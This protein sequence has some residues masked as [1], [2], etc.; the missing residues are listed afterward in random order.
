MKITKILGIIALIAISVSA[1]GESKSS[2][3]YVRNRSVKI[4]REKVGSCSGVQIIAPSGIN[5]ILSA[6]HCK[7]LGNSEG[8]FDIEMENGKLL[9]RRLIAEDPTSD[10]LLIEGAP[11]LKGLVIADKEYRFQHIRTFTHGS[12]LDTYKTEGQ[13]VQAKRIEILIAQYDDPDKVD[14]FMPKEKIIT[15]DSIIF[16]KTIY[17][18]LDVSEVVITAKIVPGSSGGMIV[19]KEGKL[20]GIASA[21]DNVFGFMVR[22]HDIKG[23]LAGY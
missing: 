8:S 15:M 17:C 6:A 12:G 18:V 20:V 9:K 4:Y 1:L 11:S 16:G 21:T 3:K 14:C 2:D 5:Y 7:S 10:L 19:D 23:F 22:L 13:I